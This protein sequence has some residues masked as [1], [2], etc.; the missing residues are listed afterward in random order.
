MAGETESYGSTSK[1]VGL[2][3][4]VSCRILMCFPKCHLVACSVLNAFAHSQC[5][6]TLRRS[7]NVY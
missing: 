2:F 4:A 6:S 5:V 7:L 3:H 1:V